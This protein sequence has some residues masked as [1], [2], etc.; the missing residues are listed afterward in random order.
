MLLPAFRNVVCSA[1]DSIVVDWFEAGF[2]WL[3]GLVFVLSETTRCT[4]YT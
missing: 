4:K 1:F 2:V 3:W